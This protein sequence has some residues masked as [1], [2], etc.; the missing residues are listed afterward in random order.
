MT[1]LITPLCDWLRHTHKVYLLKGIGTQGADRHLTSD[2]HNRRRVEH[3]IGNTRQRVGHTRATGYQSDTHLTRHA[4][5]ALGSVGGS[6]FVTHENMVETFLLTTCIVEKRVVDRHDATARVS[7]DGLH[8]F[9]LQ[10]P[11][12]RL[13]SCYSISHNLNL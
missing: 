12:Q 4:G 7:E 2:D 11:H 8:P 10:R 13:R 5:I 6:L 1:D 3:G 9:R